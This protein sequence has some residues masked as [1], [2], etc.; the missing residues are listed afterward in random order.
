MQSLIEERQEQID[1]YYAILDK[2]PYLLKE[3]ILDIPSK[4]LKKKRIPNKWTIHEHACHLALLDELILFRLELFKKM[5]QPEIK[6]F[7]PGKN[8]PDS[9][10]INLNLSE[11]LNDFQVSR[12]LIID[13]FKSLTENLWEKEG[14]H[15]EYQRYT[16]YIMLRHMAMHDH[17]H[18]YRIEELALTKDMYL[19]R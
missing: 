9:E 14:L 16:P 13:Q 10:L 19:R 12:K 18:M 3:F 15:P 11:K 8:A 7:L 2:A 1:S 5:D 17:F 4:L 6:P